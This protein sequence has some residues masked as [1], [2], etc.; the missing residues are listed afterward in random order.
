MTTENQGSQ[1]ANPLQQIGQGL[2]ALFGG[3]AQPQTGTNLPAGTQE[4]PK[5]AVLR[6]EQEEKTITEKD[7]PEGVTIREAFE[8]GAEILGLDTSREATYRKSGV[9]VVDGNVKVEWGQKYSASV[10]RST[11]G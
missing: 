9:G 1:P 8:D 10:A 4:A 11:K 7:Y 6:Y 2:R 3:L 5:S